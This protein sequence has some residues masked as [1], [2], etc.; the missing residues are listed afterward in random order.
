MGGN[1]GSTLRPMCAAE[2]DG[3]RGRACGGLRPRRAEGESGT[4]GRL[5]GLIMTAR[6]WRRRPDTAA[7]APSPGPLLYCRI[8]SCSGKSSPPVCPH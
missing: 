7:S 8:G 3:L 6:P 5:G 2:C 1:V 4:R